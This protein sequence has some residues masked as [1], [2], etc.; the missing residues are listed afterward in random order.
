MWVRLPSERC[1]QDGQRCSGSPWPSAQNNDRHP[2]M[3]VG[4][5]RGRYSRELLV[6][7]ERCGLVSFFVR[8]RAFLRPDLDSA[9]AP[10]AVAVKAGR[11]CTDATRSVVARP[12]LDRGEPGATLEGRGDWSR[13]RRRDVILD[14]AVNDECGSTA[15]PCIRSGTTARYPNLSCTGESKVQKRRDPS[16]GAGCLGP[17]VT[18]VTRLSWFTS[19]VIARGRLQARTQHG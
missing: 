16:E 7:L 15:S 2:C 17:W 18:T 3:G 8:P 12:R 13:H 6:Q 10:R 4:K 11:R 5:S 14:W 1:V 9:E 19:A